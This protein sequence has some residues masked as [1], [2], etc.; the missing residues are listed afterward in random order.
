MQSPHRNADRRSRAQ[1]K[2]GLRT[3]HGR[4]AH[5][6][7]RLRQASGAEALLHRLRDAGRQ[8][9]LRHHE[10]RQQPIM[11]VPGRYD[12]FVDPFCEPLRGLL[13]L[14]AAVEARPQQTL[15]NTLC[16]EVL[17]RYMD[18][19]K[20]R[21]LEEKDPT[22]SASRSAGFSPGKRSAVPDDPRPASY[23]V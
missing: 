18:S 1:Q 9:H 7:G 3:D 5:L 8:V 14:D 23:A 15:S 21:M 2:P 16:N 10:L 6:R 4:Y 17:K 22:T 11:K 20:Q 12:A 19:K 13:A